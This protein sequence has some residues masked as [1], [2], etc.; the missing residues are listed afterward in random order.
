M[1]APVATAP[2]PSQPAPA[3]RRNR[4]RRSRPRPTPQAQQAVGRLTILTPPA[5]SSCQAQV[6]EMNPRFVETVIELSAGQ[7]VLEIDTPAI[8]GLA[9]AGSGQA[10]SRFAAGT[11]AG[12]VPS[13]SSGAR[14][15]FNPGNASGR[16]PDIAVSGGAIEKIELRR[17]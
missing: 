13:L 15:V 12:T 5:G 3:V 17:K 7:P 14:I 16:L 4:L 9:I 1:T 10:Q 6:L 11:V 2:A 8:C